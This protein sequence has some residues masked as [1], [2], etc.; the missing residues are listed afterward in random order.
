MSYSVEKQI[1][2]P[3]DGWKAVSYPPSKSGGTMNVHVTGAETVHLTVNVN[4][5]PF[6]ASVATT[7]G[8]LVAVAA[9]LSAAEAAQIEQINKSCTQITDAALGGFYGVLGSELSASVSQQSSRLKATS[10]LLA[11]QAAAVARI[12]DTMLQDYQRIKL[13]YSKLFE[14]LDHEMQRQILELDRE[15]FLLRLEVMSK[16]VD[17]PFEQEAAVAVVCMVE[18]DE[19]QMK[20]ASAR[21]KG[22]VANSLS[23]LASL[24][25]YLKHYADAVEGVTEERSGDAAVDGQLLVPVIFVARQDL[26]GGDVRLAVVGDYAGD[27][28]I[29]KK[30]LTGI[31]LTKEDL[32]AEQREEEADRVDE[33]FDDLLSNYRSRAD[34]SGDPAL[35]D[36]VCQEIK[37][38]YAD[39]VPTTLYA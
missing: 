23:V 2:V 34:S 37:R 31:A 28:A 17:T 21:A 3:F 30:V 22:F 29:R 36:R 27:E 19:M 16:L 14:G 5:E 8:S 1:V 38:L 24:C 39:S 20:M 26:K 6:D 25:A 13:R 4:T 12:Q 18:Q 7:N 9:A 35:R 10:A 15:A 33:A 11:Q 32:W